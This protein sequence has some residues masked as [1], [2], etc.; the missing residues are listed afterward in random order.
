MASNPKKPKGSKRDRRERRFLPRATTSPA[1]VYVVGAIGGVLMGA[2]AW[3]Q[4]LR[5]VVLSASEPLPFGVWL[6]AAAAVVLAV[7]IWIGTSGEP[8]L[9]VGDGGPAVEKG[10]NVIRVPWHAVESVA[11]E[12]AQGVVVARGR[13]EA[14]D[15]LVVRARIA[16]Q[17]QAAAW[18]VREAKRRVPTVVDVGEQA[19]VPAAREDAGEMI[20]MD[21]VQVVGKRCAASGTVIAFEPDARVC[22]RCERVYHRE[23]VPE[24]CA[25]GAELLKLRAATSEPAASE[26]DEGA[27]APSPA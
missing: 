14:G 25:C 6:L 2:G 26:G 20:R 4:W 11:F 27:E 17:P 16:S 1:V 23:H 24:G 22:P 13:T 21:P 3:A 9:R 19:G 8:V 10:S 18:I 7:A 5:T 12:G 15:E